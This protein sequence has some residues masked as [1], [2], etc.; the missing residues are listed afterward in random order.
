M[1][2]EPPPILLLMSSLHIYCRDKS[3]TSWQFVKL[4]IRLTC[5]DSEPRSASKDKKGLWPPLPLYIGSYSINSVKLAKIEDEALAP[6]HFGEERFRRHN[7]LNVV[8]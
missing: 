5:L 1:G 7:P 4:P 3:Q 8:A 2:R 6:Y